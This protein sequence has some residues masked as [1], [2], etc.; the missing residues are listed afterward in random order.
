[1]SDCLQKEVNEFRM[2]TVDTFSFLH[3]ESVILGEKEN[4]GKK[5]MFPGKILNVVQ[6]LWL[7]RKFVEV[8]AYTEK[9]S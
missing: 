7:V 1:M 4:G 3:I 8:I 6:V 9:C 5:N 2:Q